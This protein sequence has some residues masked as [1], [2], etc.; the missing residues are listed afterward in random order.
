MV[1]SIRSIRR[2][3][4]SYNTIICAAFSNLGVLGGTA[5]KAAPKLAGGAKKK[6]P[7]KPARC[8]L[9]QDPTQI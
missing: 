2:R 5:G 9:S 1:C 6:P 7:M 3:R 8:R 4:E